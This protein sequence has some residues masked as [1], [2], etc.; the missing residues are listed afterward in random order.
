MLAKR[1]IKNQITLP[2]KVVNLFPKVDYFDVKTEGGKIILMPIQIDRLEKLRDRM[3][4]MN[5]TTKTI[6]D[7]VKW[8]RRQK[9]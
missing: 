6:A 1:T 3:S 5:I 2:Q 7:A 8:A 9:S 4:K